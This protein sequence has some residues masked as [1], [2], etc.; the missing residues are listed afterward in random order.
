MTIQSKLFRRSCA[1]RENQKVNESST[2]NRHPRTVEPVLALYQSAL[3]ERDSIDF[4]DMI[5]RAIQYAEQGRVKGKWRFILVNE[6]QDISEPR[7]RLLCAVKR[8]CH[9]CSLFYVGDD[10]QSIYRFTGSNVSLTTGFSSYF[11]PTAETALDL[12]FRFNDSIEKVATRFVS[13]N[14][15]QPKK[16]LSARTD[17]AGPSVRLL[18]R[19]DDLVSIIAALVVISDKVGDKKISVDILVRNWFMFLDDEKMRQLRRRFRS[20]QI[21]CRSIHAS[22]ALEA[23]CVVIIGLV[24]GKHGFPSEKATHPLLEALLPA[25]EPYEFA[26]ERQMFYVAMTGARHEAW[27]VAEMA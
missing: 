11:G 25:V 7:T 22:K 23:D 21:S 4:D 8:A 13:K 14:P 17:N 6:F 15:S 3:D 1:S 5:G 9:D 18:R 16:T 10:W 26:E 20:F 27:L 19:S 12:T 24:S 2:T